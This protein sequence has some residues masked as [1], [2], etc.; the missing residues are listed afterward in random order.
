MLDI[1]YKTRVEPNANKFY[2]QKRDKKTVLDGE[3]ND[4]TYGQEFITGSSRIP[5]WSP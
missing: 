4:E 3:G 1:L 2:P 5:R